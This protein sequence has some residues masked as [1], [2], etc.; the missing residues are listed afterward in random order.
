MQI[1]GLVIIPTYRLFRRPPE[2]PTEIAQHRRKALSY[3][4][5]QKALNHVSQLYHRLLAVCR[6]ALASKPTLDVEVITLAQQ[7][8]N[9]AL[10]AGPDEGLAHAVRTASLLGLVP[11]LFAGVLGD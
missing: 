7:Q 5:S 9:Q 6:E 8:Y 2:P 11:Y 1:F 10:G 3:D 4:A